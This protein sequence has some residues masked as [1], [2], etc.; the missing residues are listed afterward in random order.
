MSALG[1]KLTLRGVRP[2][3][4]LPP[5][6]DIRQL[7]EF[8]SHAAPIADALSTQRPTLNDSALLRG[9]QWLAQDNPE[10]KTDLILSRPLRGTKWHSLGAQLGP[11]TGAN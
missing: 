4:A 6:A 8:T 9:C 5:K 2:M 3:S 7:S 11:V 1:Q 10:R